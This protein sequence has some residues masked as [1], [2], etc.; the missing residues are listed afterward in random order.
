MAA[1]GEADAR[2]VDAVEAF[3]VDAFAVEVAEALALDV[4][5]AFPVWRALVAGEAL[6]LPVWV[7][8]DTGGE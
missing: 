6:V 4:A 3:P 8:V 1:L 7:L 5:E 2:R